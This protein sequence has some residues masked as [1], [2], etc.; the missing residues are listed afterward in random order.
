MVGRFKIVHGND[1]LCYSNGETSRR[2]WHES[3]HLCIINKNKLFIDR[4]YDVMHG[5]SCGFESRPSNISDIFSLRSLDQHFRSIAFRHIEFWNNILRIF[6][7]WYT[8]VFLGLLYNL[9]AFLRVFI[10]DD[11]CK[12]IKKVFVFSCFASAKFWAYW[13][14]CMSLQ[15][16]RTTAQNLLISAQYAVTC[17]GK[18]LCIWVFDFVSTYIQL[19]ICKASLHQDQSAEKSKTNGTITMTPIRFERFFFFFFFFF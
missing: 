8:L 17:G 6:F 12:L 7:D 2:S 10:L 9:E 3:V 1:K 11:F 19:T 4:F 15:L 13:H 18:E 14:T 5:Q 16:A